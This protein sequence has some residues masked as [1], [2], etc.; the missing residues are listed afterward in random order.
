MLIRSKKTKQTQTKTKN[1][2]KKNHPKTRK[3][4]RKYCVVKT[5]AACYAMKKYAWKC[6]Y[7]KP[8]IVIQRD[9]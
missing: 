4:R 8:T 9:M 2:N 1:L 5:L 6:I 3:E 7:L